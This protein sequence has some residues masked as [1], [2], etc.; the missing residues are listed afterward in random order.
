M[1]DER[2][3]Q[4]EER[5]VFSL[6]RR[7][8]LMGAIAHGT[9]VPIHGGGFVSGTGEVVVDPWVESED[10]FD[11]IDLPSTLAPRHWLG[12]HLWGNRLQDWQ[13]N[14]GRLECLR[15]EAG[16]ELRTVGLLTRELVSGSESGHFQV[17][18][19]IIDGANKAGFCGFLIGIGN[20][21]LDYRAAALAQRSSGCGG[22]LLCT[23]ETD[24]QVRFRDHT[25]EEHPV[26]YDELPADNTI[27]KETTETPPE[28]PVQ[29]VV[30]ILPDDE[31]R[32]T[33]QISAFDAD[34]DELLSSAVRRNVAA[35]KLVGG[36][37][38]VSSP[39]PGTDGPRW[40]FDQLQT[41]GEKIANRPD[42]TF[43]PIAGTLYSINESVMKLSAQLL[44]LSDA[45]PEIIELQYRP[46]ESNESWQ[47]THSTIDPGHTALFRIEDWDVTRTWE[48]RVVYTDAVG[49]EWHYEG[50]IAADSGTTDDLTIGLVGCTMA[51]ARQLNSPKPRSEYS[52]ASV[53]PRYTPANIYFPYETLTQNLECHDPDLL[54]A[55]GD[56]FYEMRPT[57]AEDRED[58]GLDYLYKW[59]LWLWAFRDLTRTTP[60]ITLVD[61]HDFFQGNLY[62]ARGKKTS[63]GNRKA[64]GFIGTADFV[65]RVLRTQCRH[66]PDPYDPTTIKRD[67][68][69]YYGMFTYGGTSFAL[70]QSRA[71]KLG[72]EVNKKRDPNERVLLGERQQRFL[73]AWA[74][75]NP[76]LPKICLTQTIFSDVLTTPQGK[77]AGKYDTNAYPTGARNRALRTLREAGALMLAGDQHLATLVRHGID[78]YTDGVVQFTSPAGSTLFQRWFEPNEDRTTESADSNTG[79]F[80]G[81]HGDKFQVHAVA[82]P[83]LSFTEA[84]SDYGS[85]RVFDRQLK[86]EGYGIVR[87][88]HD[89][90]KFV[91]ECWPRDC[92]PTAGDAEQFSEWP[93]RLPFDETDGRETQ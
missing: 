27:I 50:Q 66:N 36:V 57:Y 38:L 54:V 55:T 42:R 69:V 32:F 78:E 45:D 43:G 4:T 82:N 60:T 53:P 63:Q 68:S 83:K 34:T 14:D 37:S 85:R 5:S 24:G 93:Y 67:I 35:E 20:G 61:D 89:E 21:D 28:T 91:I 62:G 70:L 81:G 76:D 77:P 12:P 26:A 16:Y 7:R 33:I 84:L 9:V 75:Q 29:L 15:G 13:V 44:P 58:P 31:N 74:D 64:G 52:Q 17:R 6:S 23:F 40:W 46:T 30:D 22:G 51:S 72:P 71:F 88:N 1:S 92:D 11:P 8:F 73:E 87:V 59:Y 18:T 19:G 65:N 49:E 86:K 80:V 41:A 47:T 56:Q 90:E 39:L 10:T 48:Y 3:V 25:D 2:R 79:A